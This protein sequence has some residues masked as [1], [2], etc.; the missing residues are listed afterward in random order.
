MMI[1]PVNISKIISIY[2]KKSSVFRVKSSKEKVISLS[3]KFSKPDSNPKFY[4]YPCGIKD[5]NRK[6]VI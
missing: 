1:F 2:S 4:I 6:G 3:R 5:S